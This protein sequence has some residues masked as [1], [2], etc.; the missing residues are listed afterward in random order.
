MSQSSSTNCFCSSYRSRP[1][2]V[3][4][5]CQSAVFR[6]LVS[7]HPFWNS[8]G[9]PPA[10]HIAN[11]SIDVTDSV[12]ERM[13]SDDCEGPLIRSAKIFAATLYCKNKRSCLYQNMLYFTLYNRIGF[14]GWSANPRR[15]GDAREVYQALSLMIMFAMFVLALLTFLKKK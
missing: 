8:L 14:Q 13:F 6:I 15:G 4:P 3:F 11:L 9:G 2:S 5:K 12:S 10:A 7:N 1:S